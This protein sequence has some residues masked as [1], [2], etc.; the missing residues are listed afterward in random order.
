MAPNMPGGGRGAGR[1]G[2]SE[3]QGTP[4]DMLRT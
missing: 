4:A 3:R 1:G 2:P